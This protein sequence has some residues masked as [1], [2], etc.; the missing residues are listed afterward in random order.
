MS[1]R[2]G[3]DGAGAHDGDGRVPFLDI[4]GLA[5]WLRVSVRHVRRLVT[6]SRIPYVKVGGLVRFDP[7]EIDEWINGRRRPS[8]D[9]R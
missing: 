1:A 6:E 4:S 9:G 2:V 7:V 3:H 5:A 8:T